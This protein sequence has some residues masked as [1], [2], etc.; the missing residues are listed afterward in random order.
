MSG[1]GN[2]CFDVTNGNRID[3]TPHPRCRLD[4]GG[5]GRGILSERM[6]ELE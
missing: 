6:T 5:D 2:R 1:R 4:D 3:W